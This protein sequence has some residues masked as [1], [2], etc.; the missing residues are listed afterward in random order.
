MGN[1]LPLP[2]KGA[3]PPIFGPC[4]LRPNGWMDQ[5]ATWCRA[6]PQHR[7]LCVRWGLRSP[8]PNWH[9]P[10]IFG[11]Y[12][13]RPNGCMDQDVTWYVAR[14]RPRR[15]CVRWGSRCPLPKRG[16]TPKFSAHV[17][18]DQTAGWMKLITDMVVGFSPGEFVLDGDP[19]PTPKG[20][21][22][23]PQF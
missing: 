19:T 17:Y 7:R 5:D 23:P 22:P 10:P 16:R 13:W 3:E 4:I 6:S 1:Q 11:P 2:R 14:P 12:L 9:R 8:L 20:A 21:E 18:C 15:R